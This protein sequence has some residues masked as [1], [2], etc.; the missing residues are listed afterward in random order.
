[1]KRPNCPNV[2]VH[3]VWPSP[4]T[5]WSKI[6]KANPRDDS[7][8]AKNRHAL[9]K[10]DEL[11]K[12]AR[13]SG[14]GLMCHRFRCYGRATCVPNGAIFSRRC[15]H[16]AT[17]PPLTPPHFAPG[18]SLTTLSMTQR[19]SKCQRE[20]FLRVIVRVSVECPCKCAL[21]S[22]IESRIDKLHHRKRH[23][24]SVLMP[25]AFHLLT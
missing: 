16:R 20:R 21:H 2:Q 14:V 19:A 4:T 22:A 13:L 25:D 11:T 12:V 15:A 1:M 10:G 3:S 9:S 24:A 5:L 6:I 7:D 17:R 8:N 18:G 23:R